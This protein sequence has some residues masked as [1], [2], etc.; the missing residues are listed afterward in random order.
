MEDQHPNLQI[1]PEEGDD[2]QQPSRP[3]SPNA[4]PPYR[5]PSIPTTSH[6]TEELRRGTRIRNPR[7]LPDNTYGNRPPVE[8]ERDLE[9]QESPRPTNEEDDL[10]TL[11]SVNFWR[12]I[13]ASAAP[14]INISQQYWDILKLPHTEQELWRKAMNEEIKS[15][16]ERKVWDLVA[17]PPGRIPIKGRWVYAVKSDGRKKARFVAKGFTQIFGIDFEETFSLV[18][19]FE[20]V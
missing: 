9:A 6:D 16:S 19:R 2:D 14:V 18:A 5:S 20:T 1:P 4:P 15:L 12:K 8:I 11:Y 7:F 3:S 13:I 10:G 17:L